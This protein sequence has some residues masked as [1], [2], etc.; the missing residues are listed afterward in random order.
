MLNLQEG[1]QGEKE[2]DARCLL[3]Q[4]EEGG[5]LSGIVFFFVRLFPLLVTLLFW[6]QYSTMY[7]AYLEEIKEIKEEEAK[8]KGE[9]VNKLPETEE[10]GDEKKETSAQKEPT[11][12]TE[13]KLM[14]AEAKEIICET[15]FESP[16]QSEIEQLVKNET[17]PLAEKKED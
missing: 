1:A 3:C 12:E 9:E 10:R 6:K 2:G 16:T 13:I 15:T 17:K 4:G 11:E 7:Q 14:E 8:T 5:S